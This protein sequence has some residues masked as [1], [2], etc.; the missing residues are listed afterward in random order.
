MTFAADELHANLDQ[1]TAAMIASA[2][3]GSN[4]VGIKAA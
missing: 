2:A 4:N 3:A 1:S